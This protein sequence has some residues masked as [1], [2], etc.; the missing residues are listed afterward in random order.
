[1]EAEI[2]IAINNILDLARKYPE[3]VVDETVSV[4]QVIVARLEK[5]VVEATPSGVGGAAGLRGSIHGRVLALAGLS[6]KGTVG[7]PLPYG[8][9]VEHGRRPLKGFPPVDP[10]ALWAMRKLGVP[11]D[12]AQS[13]GF[14]IARKIAVK[15]TEGVHM[16]ENAW[17]ANEGWVMD[18]LQTI[19]E[20]VARR[21][22]S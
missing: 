8:K 12:E 2:T 3:A 14:L 21:L 1:M 20:K 13:V 7:T 9:V 22:E 19:P 16:F 15:G 11:A 6:V 5:D 18:Q 17:K 4:M 10:I